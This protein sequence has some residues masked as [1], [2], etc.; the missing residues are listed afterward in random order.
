M[1]PNSDPQTF[2][3]YQS[4]VDAAN[5]RRAERRPL[6]AKLS[7]RVQPE[8]IE[9]ITDNLSHIGVLFFSEEPLRVLIDVESEG[10]KKTYAGRLVRVQR[11]SEKNTGFAVEFDR[12]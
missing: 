9:G 4:A 8:A 6:E 2:D 12:D 3:S 10:E 5:R 1:D 7:L 11:M